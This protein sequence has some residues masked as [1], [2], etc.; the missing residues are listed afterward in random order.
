M[1]IPTSQVKLSNLQSEFGGSNPI[2]LHEYYAGAGLVTNPAPTSG[3]QSAIIPTGGV[4]RLSNFRGVAKVTNVSSATWSG[5]RAVGNVS[6]TAPNGSFYSFDV[7]FAP[8]GNLYLLI[9]SDS[10][11]D[12]TTSVI[13]IGTVANQTSRWYTPTTASIGNNYWVRASLV[14]GS[15]PNDFSSN[16]SGSFGLNSWWQL[17]SAK[18]FGYKVN[19]GGSSVNGT[20]KFE[21]SS[22]SSGSPI[23]A[24]GQ[25][26]MS[27]SL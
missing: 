4:I 6:Q 26:Q 12:F 21:I 17:N 1:A 15:T 22:S 5:G 3:N 25:V 14:S 7:S 23:L 2:S 9:S 24:T 27:I 18:Y 8:N 13:G 16:G 11:S 10:S 20:L 19:A